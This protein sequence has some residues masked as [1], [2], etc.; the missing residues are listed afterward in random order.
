MG[1]QVESILRIFA[2]SFLK[3]KDKDSKTPLDIVLEK[4]K[5]AR[6]GGDTLGT[7]QYGKTLME[8]FMFHI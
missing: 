1:T 3:T 2:E 7:K 8:I 4:Y 6:C 5:K